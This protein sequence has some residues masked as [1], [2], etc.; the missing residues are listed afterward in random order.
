MTE[1]VENFV[2]LAVDILWKS[3]WAVVCIT[4]VQM[5]RE[6]R[7]WKRPVE[8]WFFGFEKKFYFEIFLKNE[9]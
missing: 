3:T 7:T 2:R 6:N 8:K 9:Y 1:A 4:G 5:T